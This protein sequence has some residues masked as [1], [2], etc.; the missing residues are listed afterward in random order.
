MDD[1]IYNALMEEIRKKIPQNSQMVKTLVD[2]LR[3]EKEAVYRRLR[4]E[5]P[6]TFNEVVI[7]SRKLSISLDT[8]IGTEIN[9]SRPFQMKLPDFLDFG[10]D[11]E[12]MVRGFLEML[13]LTQESRHSETGVVSNEIPQPFFS[14]FPI[15]RKFY[16][17]NW[18]FYFKNKALNFNDFKVSD[19]A[20]ES[21]DIRF[22]QTKNF[23][24]SHY[25]FDNYVFQ[26]FVNNI[27]YFRDIR[28]LNPYEVES[29]KEEL[30]EIID[31]IENLAVK[32]KFDETGNSVYIYI[33]DIELTTNYSYFEI[34]NLKISMIKAFLLTS[35]TSEDPEIFATTKNW[36]HSLI[37]LSTQISQT[38]ERQRIL[39]FDKQ[40]QIVN[41]L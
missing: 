10:Q 28:L 21:F 41:K 4:Q 2:I 12:I 15:I 11:S 1:K 5:V 18:A 38:N 27:K 13:R 9:R 29:I 3:I 16:V 39:Y 40:R 7:I 32:G 24:N 33:S 14:G 25:V 30:F 26:H 20:S 36:I 22:Q 23:K 19:F 35:A 17:F 34:D 37:K 6:F 8:I 31:Y